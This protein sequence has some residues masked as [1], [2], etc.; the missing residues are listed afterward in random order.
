MWSLSLGT[1]SGDRDSLDQ[2]LGPIPWT[3]HLGLDFLASVFISA[4]S[5]FSK[6]LARRLWLESPQTPHL[7]RGIW[8]G[9]IPKP[10]S[11]PVLSPSGLQSSDPAVLLGRESLL[12]LLRLEMSLGLY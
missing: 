5:A 2:T 9:R 6:D 10:P 8:P 3:S 4:S 11:A 12:A 1:Q 7:T